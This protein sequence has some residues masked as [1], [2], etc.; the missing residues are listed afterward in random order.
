[1]YNGIKNGKEPSIKELF[2]EFVE[3]VWEV[4]DDDENDLQANA[5]KWWEFKNKIKELL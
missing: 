2:L 1:M 5:Q 4:I 3:L